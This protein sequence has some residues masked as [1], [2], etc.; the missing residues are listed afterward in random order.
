MQT[1]DLIKRGLHLLLLAIRIA[2]GVETR[3]GSIAFF[4]CFREKSRSRRKRKKPTS[5]EGP[6]NLGLD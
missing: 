2:A 5:M 6:P 3:V 1:L 4:R